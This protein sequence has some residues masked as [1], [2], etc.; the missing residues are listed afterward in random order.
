ML[1]SGADLAAWDTEAQTGALSF[2]FVDGS[3]DTGVTREVTVANYGDTPQ[4]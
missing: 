3:Q 1:H 4:T 2:G